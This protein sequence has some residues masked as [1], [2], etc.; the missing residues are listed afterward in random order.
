MGLFSVVYSHAAGAPKFYS[1]LI[2]KI[3]LPS[4]FISFL[5]SLPQHDILRESKLLL[6]RY[7][8]DGTDGTDILFL[9]LSETF[10]KFVHSR[11]TGPAVVAGAGVVVVVGAGVTAA[12]TG[13]PTISWPV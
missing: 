11:A 13:S 9:W 5:F 1:K 3:S 12:N 6:V 7:G 10:S 4:I 8:T 2:C